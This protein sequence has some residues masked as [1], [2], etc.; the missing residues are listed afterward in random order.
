[1]AEP[2]S[3]CFGQSTARKGQLQFLALAVEKDKPRLMFQ[4]RNMPANS[5]LGNPDFLRTPR[6]IAMPCGRLKN[7]QG[8]QR[9]E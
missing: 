4:L 8:V 6:Q 2:K 1:V 5:G 3:D 7:R 9:G